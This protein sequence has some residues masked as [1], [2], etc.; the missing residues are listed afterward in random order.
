VGAKLPARKAKSCAVDIPLAMRNAAGP[1]N[2]QSLALICAAAHNPHLSC[3]APVQ[4]AT[5]AGP[6][7]SEES[8][9]V[10]S[11]QHPFLNTVSPPGLTV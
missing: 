6:F 7:V 11:V 2:A 4:R 3:F 8:P 10:L 5:F 9:D 1:A